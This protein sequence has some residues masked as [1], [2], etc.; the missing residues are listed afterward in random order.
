MTSHPAPTETPPEAAPDAA[1]DGPLR[2]GRTS[3]QR[4]WLPPLIVLSVLFLIFS[5][6]PYLGFDPAKSRLPTRADYPLHYPLL[7]G[8]IMFG[9]VALLAG[10]LQVWPWLRGRFPRVHRWSGRLYLFGGVFPAGV[11]VLGVAPVSSTGFTSAVG[12]TTLAVLWLGTAAAGYRAARQ[13]RFADHRTWMVRNFALT[14][15]IVFNRVWLILFLILIDV[16]SVAGLFGGDETTR[17]QTAA[18]ASVWLSWVANLLFA[19]WYVLRRKPAPAREPAPPR[20]PPSAAAR[21][22]R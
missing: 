10:C 11:L 13:R 17:I 18:A 5:L 7:V 19:E 20:H 9:S 4:A 8:H 22:R 21:P 6:P 15:S 3:R 16:P 2:R 12:N 1:P 14:L